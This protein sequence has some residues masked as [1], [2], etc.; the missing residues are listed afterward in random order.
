MSGPML[1]S[2]LVAR[3]PGLRVLFMSGYT[4]ETVVRD[5]VLDA[6]NAFLQKPFTSAGLANKV[7]QVLDAVRS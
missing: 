1:A 3:R 6:G 7:R 4:D 2:E 5:G